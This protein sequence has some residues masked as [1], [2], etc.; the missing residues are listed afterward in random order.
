M[1]RLYAAPFPMMGRPPPQDIWA[2]HLVQRPSTLDLNGNGLSLQGEY[3]Y[4]RFPHGAVPINTKSPSTPFEKSEIVPSPTDSG[5]S[6]VAATPSSP[7]AAPPGFPPMV[8]IAETAAE[9]IRICDAERTFKQLCQRLRPLASDK[10]CTDLKD[11]NEKFGSLKLNE[12]ESEA[13]ASPI[14]PPPADANHFVGD[15]IVFW[16]EN[17]PGLNFEIVVSGPDGRIECSA[18]L[19]LTLGKFCASFMTPVPGIYIVEVTK[20]SDEEMQVNHGWVQA[21]SPPEE[22]EPISFN[23]DGAGIVVGKERVHFPGSPFKVPVHRN[24][25]LAS[26]RKPL[27]HVDMEL[28]TYYI[29]ESLPP[30][31]RLQEAEDLVVARKPWGLAINTHT[32][33]MYVTDR[34]QHQILVYTHLGE[35]AFAFGQHGRSTGEFRRPCGIAYDA[36][37]D[38]VYVTDKDNHRVQVFNAVGVFMFAFGARGKKNGQ[39]AFPWGIDVNRV[40]TLIVVADSRNHRLQLF[41]EHG[42]FMRKIA[43]RGVFF[44]YPRGVAFDPTGQ[45]IFSTDFNLHHVLCTDVEFKHRCRVVVTMDQLNRPQSVH[46]DLT[47]QLFVTSASDSTIKVFNAWTG[48]PLYEISSV[49]DSPIELPLNSASIY[50]GNLAILEMN[51]KISII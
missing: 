29:N 11:A 4:G 41:N 36:Y 32:Q 40:G 48:N 26:L 35:P 17:R 31:M 44:D 49:G 27:V 3:P 28:D 20:L 13:Q 16:I 47:G 10:S 22:P 2:R 6:T 37:L 46:V 1:E 30:H 7:F 33:M 19:D 23:L 39:F 38:R 45:Y 34:E 42:T 14:T 21:P 18:F 15:K 43:D 9:T 8:S 50:Q 51:G 25:Y 24:F 12:H 5:Y